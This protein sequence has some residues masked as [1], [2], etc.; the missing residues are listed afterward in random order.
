[1]HPAVYNY[2]ISWRATSS[3]M[4][5]LSIRLADS[6]RMKARA[7]LS[8]S[9]DG[10]RLTPAAL[11]R[12]AGDGFLV[13]LCRLLAEHRQVTYLRP[14]SEMNNGNNSYS[15][16]DLSGRPRGP[17]FST[18]QFKRAWRRL[19]LVVRGGEVAAIND[20]LRRL[21]M[22]PVQT[23]AAQLPTPASRSAVGAAVI[24]EPRDSE[25]PSA[26]L[27]AGRGVRGLGRHHLVF[28]VQAIVGDG[29]P[30]PRAPLA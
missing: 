2:F 8:V 20:S 13:A 27:L 4:H 18:A 21:G 24:R 22:P 29:R 3:D 14:L 11:A 19:A 6:T 7:L 16:Y 30:L 12:G 10:T 5:W 25:E 9:T 28:A 26:A 17:A 1:M 23:A 15:A